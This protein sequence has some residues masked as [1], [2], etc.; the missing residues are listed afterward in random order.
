MV[1]IYLYRMRMFYVSTSPSKKETKKSREGQEIFLPE[2]YTQ[3]S[4]K[5]E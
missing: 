5:I 1:H 2:A 4:I 3:T